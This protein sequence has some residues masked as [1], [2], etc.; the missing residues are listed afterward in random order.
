MAQPKPQT[1]LIGGLLYTLLFAAAAENIGGKDSDN[2]CGGEERW[3]VKVVTD[4]NA[5]KAR[6][7]FE[8]TTIADLIKIDTKKPENKYGEDKPR[9]EIETHL[10]KI[11]HC[12]ITDVLREN[13][14]DLHLVIEDGAGNHMIA[15][16]PD[17]KCSEA[18]KSDWIGNFE[19]ARNTL[20]Q[21][22]NNYRHFMFSI[23]G[24]LFVDK[25]HGQTG[26][27]PNNVEL[28]PIIEIKKEKKINPILQ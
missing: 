8:E 21:F 26:R 24:F 18:Q 28:H 17:P 3:N 16:I 20:V 23:T 11:R 6:S 27:A 12:F 14:N 7:G 9:M 4:P 1:F 2:K 15:E 25:K 10:Y 5:D 13:D 22:S 19:E